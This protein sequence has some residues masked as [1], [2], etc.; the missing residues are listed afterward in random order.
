M[1]FTV[2]YELCPFFCPDVTIVH[3]E[4]AIFWYAQVRC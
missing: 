1:Y 3:W 2:Y 4:E